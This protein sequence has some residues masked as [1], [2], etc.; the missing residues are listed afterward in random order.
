MDGFISTLYSPRGVIEKWATKNAQR[1]MPPRGDLVQAKDNLMGLSNSFFLPAGNR[2]D[3]SDHAE[4]NRQCA[5]QIRQLL[6]A[7]G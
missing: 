5:N 2:E 3:K 7:P 4:R 1:E 6:R